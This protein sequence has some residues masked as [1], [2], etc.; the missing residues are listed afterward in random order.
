MENSQS[1]D[2]PP[3]DRAVSR[4][5]LACAVMVFAMLVVGGITRLT[6]SG[7]SMVTWRPIS[8]ALPPL[9]TPDWEALF[10][11]YRRSPQ[12]VLENSTMTLD[13]FQRIFWWEYIHRLLGRVTGLVFA[14]PLALFWRAGRLP[15]LL[16]RRLP[17][18]AALGMAQG[19]MGWWMVQSG[20][21]RDPRVS[22][23]RLALHLGM[24]FVLAGLLVRTAL[25]LRAR[26]PRA[27]HARR[28]ARGADLLAGAVFVMALSGALVAGNH[29]GLAFNT[30]PLML[31][32][33][34][35]PGLYPLAP[36][37]ESALFDVMTVQFNHRTLALA[38]TV[39]VGAFGLAA[40]RAA[41]GARARRWSGA[42]VGVFCAQ[43]ALGVATLLLAV[44]TWLAV[45]H[46]ANAMALFLTTVAAGRA[47]A[48]DLR[49]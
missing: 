23:V 39:A 36:W 45:L 41:L 15:P 1:A 19:A 21:V 18:I 31:G 5:L 33:L 3:E 46:Q 16:R 43:F 13:G 29:A 32:R 34:A 27:A 2:R 12:F 25:D 42:V 8:G 28:L 11:E 10:A 22:P 6:G 20:L 47:I 26:G 9:S 7:L 35:P 24:A 30:W 49:A 40:R 14:V 48:Q 17:A 44:P 4:W 37:Y 38:L